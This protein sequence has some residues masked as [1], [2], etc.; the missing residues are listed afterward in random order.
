MHQQT[1]V[2]SAIKIIDLQIESPHGTTIAFVARSVIPCIRSER[3]STV[4][5]HAQTVDSL[6]TLVV[7]G[8]PIGGDLTTVYMNNRLCVHAARHGIA[9]ES[10][11]ARGSSDPLAFRLCSSPPQRQLV[12]Q[13]LSKALGECSFAF[14]GTLCKCTNKCLSSAP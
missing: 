8:S 7:L 9:E 10:R 12:Q 2:F 13:C 5:H 3:L 1:S 6:L 11:T 14:L 4:T